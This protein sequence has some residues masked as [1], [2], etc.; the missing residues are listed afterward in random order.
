MDLMDFSGLPYPGMTPDLRVLTI[1]S[2]YAGLRHHSRSVSRGHARYSHA[3]RADSL[4]E[5]TDL[6][7][8]QQ[9]AN[10][11]GYV[12]YIEPGPAPGTNTAYWGPQV[13]IGIPQPALNVNMDTWTNVESLNFRYQPQRR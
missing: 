11:A 8:I 13:R 5:D 1:L 2:K 7:Y 3:R 9:L 12:F 10:D 6:S 4:A